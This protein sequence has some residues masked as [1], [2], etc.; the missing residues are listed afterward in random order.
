MNS[1][2]SMKV[3]AAVTSLKLVIKGPATSA[4]SNPIFPH[5]IGIA[6]PNALASNIPIPIPAVTATGNSKFISPV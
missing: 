4:G 2:T 1:V 5:N 3:M 6:V